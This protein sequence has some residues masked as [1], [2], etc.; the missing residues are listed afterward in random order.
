VIKGELLSL[1]SGGAELLLIKEI[2]PGQEI[3][4]KIRGLDSEM[5]G[6]LGA[7]VQSG[8][9]SFDIDAK[10]VIADSVAAKDREGWLVTVDKLSGFKLLRR[11]ASGKHGRS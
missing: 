2:A 3:A 6:A 5:A 4:L 8:S 11:S 9:G 1:M 7:D 10:G